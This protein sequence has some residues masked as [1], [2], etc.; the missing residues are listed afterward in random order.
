MKG[1]QLAGVVLMVFGVL[2]LAY[3][4]FTYTKETHEASLGSLSLSVA[5]KERFNI[6]VWA[7]VGGVLIGGVMFFLG[8]P[9]H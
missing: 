4:G 2:A 3:G 7:G 9:S 6:P 5:D 8:R 1:Y